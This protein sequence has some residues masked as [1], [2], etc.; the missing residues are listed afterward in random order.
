MAQIL[1][2]LFTDQL[3]KKVKFGVSDQ[4]LYWIHGK[5]NKHY[6]SDC[7]EVTKNKLCTTDALR[8]AYDKIN[9]L[10][11]QTTMVLKKRTSI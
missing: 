7:Y 4:V 6:F 8:M 5:S 10:E 2:P 11:L 9:K 3:L 1:V